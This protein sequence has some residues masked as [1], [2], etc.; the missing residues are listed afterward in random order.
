MYFAHPLSHI[1][2]PHVYNSVIPNSLQVVQM[3]HH[4][5]GI[6]IV[7]PGTS[8]ASG[9]AQSG[10]IWTGKLPTED[11]ELSREDSDDTSTPPAKKLALDLGSGKVTLTNSR[12]HPGVG[13]FIMTPGGSIVPHPAS[14]PHLI[15]MAAPGQ[16]QLPIVIPPSVSTSSSEQR[17]MLMKQSENAVTE[18]WSSRSQIT[19]GVI[20]TTQHK[21]YLTSESRV[22]HSTNL[23]QMS[24]R[25]QLAG[26][27]IPPVTSSLGGRS[28]NSSESETG[29]RTV[30]QETDRDK[31]IWSPEQ[32]REGTATPTASKMPFA[33]ISIRSGEW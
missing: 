30:V 13:S 10:V 4:I 12:I 28:T 23:I 2:T 33:N 25:P 21:D 11:K 9:H 5:P 7:V 15:Q 29:Q 26:L 22:H 17:E 27:V 14:T 24:P 6:P 20:S 32:Q 16:P 19:G 18:N 3:T 31:R 8:V 1:D